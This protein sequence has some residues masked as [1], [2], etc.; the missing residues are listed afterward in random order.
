MGNVA[1][2]IATMMMNIEAQTGK[3]VSDWIILAR[4]TGY[5][6][7][8]EILK[9]LK[10][11]HGMSHGYANHV[12]KEALKVDGG[13]ESDLVAAQYAGKKA[14]LM[15]LYLAIIK[16]CTSLGDDVEI[17]PKKNNV[18]IRRNKQFALLQA[19]TTDRIDVGLI[20]KNVE[21]NGR[22]ETSGSFN[23]MFTHR[24]RIT[25]EKDIDQELKAWL[26]A[27]YSSS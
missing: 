6:K 15:P 12:A 21:P 17:A 23:A 24:V 18:S 8:S 25:T 26:K 10:T 4:K 5:S 16:A 1:D 7:H 3:R 27:A 13:D 9:W 14:A 11:E 20:L 2:A 22:L 19:S